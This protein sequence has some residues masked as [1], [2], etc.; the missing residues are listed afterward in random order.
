MAVTSQDNTRYCPGEEQIRISD[1]ICFG[2]QRNNFPKC[3]GCPFHEKGGSVAAIVIGAR[4]SNATA[5]KPQAEEAN[6]VDA[7]F[8]ANDIRGRYPDPLNEDVA[9]RIGQAVAQFLRSELRGYDRTLP[10]K[11]TV[12]VGRDMRKSSPSLAASLIEGL[13]AGGSPVVDIGMVDTPQLYF[14]VHRLTCCGGVQVTGSHNPPS[15]N[16]F[17]ICSVKGRP[18]SVDTGLTKVY[19]IARH[20]LRHRT[21]PLADHS[22]QD[23]SQDYKT[24]VRS[25]LR[26]DT[27][28]VDAEHPLKIVIDA[29]N[30]MAGR[31]VPLI[32]GDIPWLEI[33][34]L[35]F[36]HNGEFLHDP[37]PLAESNLSQL[38]DRVLRAQAHLG[39]CF[40]GDA[41]RMILVDHEGRPVGGDL[42]T[43]LL[44][45][46]FLD[47]YPGSTVAY[48]LRSSR[49]VPE[50][51]RKAGGSPRPERS[52]HAY[53]K[54]AL[55]DAKGSFAGELSGHY[56]FRDNGYCDS[57]MIAFAEILNLLT[58]TNASLHQLLAP[59]RRY[60]SSPEQSFRCSNGPEIIDRV[61]KHYAHGEANF[62][63]GVTVRFPD[64]W[65]NLRSSIT[66]PYIR[67]RIEAADET[68]VAVKLDE[69]RGII[70][71]SVRPVDD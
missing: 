30:G 11:N 71:S 66:G 42:I 5:G 17:K 55:S 7:L 60:A 26:E 44:A 8:K 41:D 19:R 70:V 39:V 47:R 13:R 38:C 45:P 43:A 14:A 61:A 12:V 33:V 34:R 40:D 68:M 51:I 64:W 54:K 63:D 3:K 36:E 58:R 28:T 48:D 16:G 31:A 18:V 49:V 27:L 4:R 9:W 35:N 46:V 23:L 52:G 22:S 56:Y 25:F 2:R 6:P 10:E 20:T 67:L 57:G 37:N 65:F 69:V 15:E 1:A 24:F 62:L 53:L 21:G 59:L 32:F 50:E 29:S